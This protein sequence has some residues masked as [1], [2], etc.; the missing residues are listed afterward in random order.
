[1][2][3]LNDMLAGVIGGASV[4]VKDHVLGYRR[5]KDLFIL[6]VEA[7]GREDEKT[8][9]FVVKIGTESR[10]RREIQGWKVC[11]P[12]GL[13][14]DLV[15]LELREGTTL[16]LDGEDWMSLVYGDAQQFL[17]VTATITFEDAALECVRS[18][19]PRFPSIEFVIVELF[20]RIGHLLYSQAFVDDPT[21]EGYVF[22]RTKL[23]AAMDRWETDPACQAARREVNTLARSGVERFLDPVDYL[24]YIQCYVPWKDAAA[25]GVAVPELPGVPR[26]M[27]VQVIPRLL[28]RR[29]AW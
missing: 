29:P 12:P 1:M 22:D 28:P 14:H 10:L 11:R 25:A 24:R 21:R 5:K 19:F 8:G 13:K 26:P 17:G 18:G 9:P 4:V 2:D 15:F 27:P 20:E 6:M 3:R 23:A 7:F 16:Q